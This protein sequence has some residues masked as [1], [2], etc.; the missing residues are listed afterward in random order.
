MDGNSFESSKVCVAP[1][2]E[3][4][5]F[6]QKIT[7][8]D[9]VINEY[10]AGNL[11]TQSSFQK[12]PRVAHKINGTENKHEAERLTTGIIFCLQLKFSRDIENKL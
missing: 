5:E 10:K 2:S 4:L 8:D 9:S 6:L 3:V 1:K 12:G 7:A 11:S